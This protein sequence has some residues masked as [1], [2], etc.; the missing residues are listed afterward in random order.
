MNIDELTAFEVK[1]EVLI[2]QNEGNFNA[3][4]EPI[5]SG[6]GSGWL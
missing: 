5:D 6:E 4:G 3:F 1:C 2:N